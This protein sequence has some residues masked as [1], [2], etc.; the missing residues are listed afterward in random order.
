M[1][2]LEYARISI[3]TGSATLTP[4]LQADIPAII[5]FWYHGGA[6]HGSLGIDPL[7][8]GS[9]DDTRKRFE[10]ALITGDPDQ[11]NAAFAIRLDE[12]LV[13]YS[14]LN[15]YT[16]EINHSHWHIIEPNLR[17]TGI[18]SALY[19]YRIDTYFGLYPIRRLIHLCRTG[20]APLPWAPV[21]LPQ[22]RG[23]PYAGQVYSGC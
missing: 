9:S 3:G 7:M 16:P 17:G 8:L 18:S 23:K 20:S 6:D 22:P 11:S 13:G 5:D 10:S 14:L 21:R 12:R 15:R 19:P 2:H 4:L 1:S